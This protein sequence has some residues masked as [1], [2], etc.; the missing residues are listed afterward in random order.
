MRYNLILR[1]FGIIL[2]GELDEMHLVVTWIPRRLIR[3]SYCKE[4]WG[5]DSKK[6]LL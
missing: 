3:L 5:K 4:F 2:I 1:N 6:L